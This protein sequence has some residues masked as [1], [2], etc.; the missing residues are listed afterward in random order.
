MSAAVRLSMLTSHLLTCRDEKV[1]V[2][3]EMDKI[4]AKVHGK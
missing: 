3:G 1:F 2:E 4:V